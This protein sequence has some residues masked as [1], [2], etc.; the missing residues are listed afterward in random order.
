[1]RSQPQAVRVVPGAEWLGAAPT[2]WTVQPL[3]TVLKE[4][5]RRNTGLRERNLLSLSYGRIVRK[6]IDTLEGLLPESFET[7]QIVESGDIVLRLTDLQNDHRSLRV[8]LVPERGIITSAYVNLRTAGDYDPRYLFYQL[9]NADLRKVFYNF[10]GGVRQSMKYADLKRI[11]TILPPSDEQRAIADFLDCETAKIDELLAAKR[12]LISSLEAEKTELVSLQVLGCQP[13]IERSPSDSQWLGSVP[14]HWKTTR[15]KYATSLIV[16][17]PHETP[18]YSADGEYPVV[19]TA[20]ISFGALTFAGTLR[21][22]SEEFEKRVRRA[23]VLPG[24]IVY[25]REGERWGFAATVPDGSTVCLGQRMMQFRAAAHFDSRYLMWHL[26]A[27]CVYVQGI[28]D[29]VGAT[30]PHV[31]VDTIRNY[32]L[33]EPPLTEQRQIAMRLDS[34]LSRIDD[35][36]KTVAFGIERTSEFRSAL[37][38]AA[39]TGQIDVR[40][41]R[42]Q[43][44][45]AVCP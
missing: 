9:H 11:P 7:Y 34:E 23:K 45:A 4:T 29:T 18:V 1:V 14:S 15:L 26:N 35:L 5:N 3:F 37:I 22:D 19:R 21:V 39:V 32:C 24:D 13:C 30:S 8:G 16:D 41:Y 40:T 2:C 43:E 28:V 25:G 33:A 27:R 42:P 17:C 31:N 12:A 20:D 44:N 6:D 38:S 10:G 36:I